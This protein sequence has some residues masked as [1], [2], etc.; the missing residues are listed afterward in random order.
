MQHVELRSHTLV[1]MGVCVFSKWCACLLFRLRLL[2][3]RAIRH[4]ILPLVQILYSDRSPAEL[5]N[6]K[7]TACRVLL[8][9]CFRQETVCNVRRQPALLQSNLNRSVWTVRHLRFSPN[10]GW[11]TSK[12]VLFQCESSIYRNHT[13]HQNAEVFGVSAIYHSLRLYDE[14]G[15]GSTETQR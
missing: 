15:L 6:I 7:F 3:T 12:R 8:R 10:Y 5:E 13:I 4:S 14:M 1:Y 11:R 2:A 9:M